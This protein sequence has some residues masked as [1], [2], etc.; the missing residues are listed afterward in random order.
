[1]NEEEDAIQHMLREHVDT[2]RGLPRTGILQTRDRLTT[3]TELG[4][5]PMLLPGR[6]IEK[7]GETET[8]AKRLHTE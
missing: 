6:T 1:M 8:A 4:P 7:I 3:P 2:L 5:S